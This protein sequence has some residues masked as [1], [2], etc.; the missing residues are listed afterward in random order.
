M[1]E[2]ASSLSAANKMLNRIWSDIQ[3]ASE[4]R[5]ADEA[6][7]D[8]KKH[9]DCKIIADGKSKAFTYFES[10]TAR[11]GQI[12]RWCYAKNP[13]VAGYYLSWIEVWKGS[14]GA[15]C[16]WHGWETKKAA[17]EDCRARYRDSKKPSAD[18][19]YTVP[20]FKLARTR[21]SR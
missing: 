9:R 19:R 11:R 14:D 6:R 8:P 15:R 4:R 5:V 7:A 12:T 13:N 18:R 21:A 2:Q 3:R 17:I 16:T 1:N 20:S 10:K